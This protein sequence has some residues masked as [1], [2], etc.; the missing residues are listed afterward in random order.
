MID[1]IDGVRRNAGMPQYNL[2]EQV[3]HERQ[4]TQVAGAFDGG[5][6]AAL[7]LEAVA[8]DAAGQ[9]FALFVD[10]LNEEI[11]VFVINVLDAEFAETAVFSLI[12]P[13]FRIA[14]KFYVFSRSSHIVVKLESE[15]IGGFGRGCYAS[16]V[17]STSAASR[18]TT[19]GAATTVSG[20]AAG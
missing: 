20:A 10:E 3:A 9:Q 2:L 18:S 7:V 6:H 12:Q 11:G 15:R 17:T 8:G 16:A 14:E 19:A 1:E 5:S 13:D 4:H